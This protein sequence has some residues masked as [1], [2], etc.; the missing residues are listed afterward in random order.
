MPKNN[1]KRVF[2]FTSVAIIEVKADQ[3]EEDAKQKFADNS[4]DFAANAECEEITEY[5]SNF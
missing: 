2:K 3:D 4:F 1:Q 5:K